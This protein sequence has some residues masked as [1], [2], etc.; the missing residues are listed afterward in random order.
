MCAKFHDERISRLSVLNRG[1]ARERMR[2]GRAERAA[3]RA[4]AGDG[5][6]PILALPWL[7]AEGMP[8]AAADGSVLALPPVAAEGLP[9]AADPAPPQPVADEVE[10]EEAAAGTP[11]SKRRR[12]GEAASPPSS[13]SSS[14]SDWR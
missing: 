1:Q 4:V 14:S 8:N 9:I 10:H 2:L 11:S 5:G 12:V 3:Q 7:A 13:S 6:G